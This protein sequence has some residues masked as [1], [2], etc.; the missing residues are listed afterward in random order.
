MPTCTCARFHT[1]THTHTRLRTRTH[2]HTHTHPHIHTGARAHRLVHPQAHT[3]VHTYTHTH[4]HARAHTLMHI[5]CSHASRSA[6]T[7]LVPRLRTS[8]SCK[9]IIILS[10]NVLPFPSCSL[11]GHSKWHYRVWRTLNP[12][13]MVCACGC[14]LSFIALRG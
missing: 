8:L 14:S 11:G 2:T 13:N 7:C 12:R 5:A 9:W 10:L 1:H 6:T 3:H 4:R